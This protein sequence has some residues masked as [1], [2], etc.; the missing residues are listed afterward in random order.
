MTTARQALTTA[1]TD[2]RAT[3]TSLD[4]AF[5]AGAAAVV[6]ALCAS[7]IPALVDDS[8]IYLRIAANIGTGQGWLYNLTEVSNA[9][10]STSYTL[11]VAAIGLVLG[12]SEATL[13]TAYGLTLY[14]LWALQ[15]A[16]WHGEGRGRAIAIA[17]GTALG[18]VLLRSFGMESPLMLACVSA[19]ALSYRAQGDSWRT[20]A[21]AGLTALTRPEGIALLGLI[22]LVE[23]VRGRR[24]AWRSVLAAGLVILPWVA[25]ATWY[26]GT[27]RSQTGEIKALQ[28]HMGWWATQPGFLFSFLGQPRWLPATLA[29]A[30]GGAWLAVRRWLRGDAFALLCIGFGVIQVLGYQLM[31]APSGYVWY[32]IPGNFAVDLGV[33]LFGTWGIGVLARR[34]SW[35]PALAVAVTLVAL[36]VLMR[37]GMSPQVR[38][39][40][41]YRLAAEYRA[42]GH[43]LDAH[44]APGDVVAAT[45]IG[46]LGWYSGLGVL[47][48]HGLAHPRA[49]PWLRQHNL[50]WWWDTGER[51]RYV[52]I[53]DKPWFGEPGSEETWPPALNAEFFR[54]YRPAFQYE[55]LRVFER[56]G[57]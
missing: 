35:R 9:A 16:A 14:A 20:G 4:A 44:G 2:E 49:V 23:L 41:E 52:V 56:N 17:T 26:F 57:S 22:G 27:A 50:H 15:Y 6:T 24:I 10:T 47:D 46:Y 8:F 55:T 32:F 19:T 37:L 33:M 11:L 25:F 36:P 45:E 12:Y 1:A 39:P 38:L 28:R 48:I 31:D 7:L 30:T 42:V 53:H 29:L 13:A 3:W 40:G 51:P 5:L 34:F 43:W 18:G 21:L 54:Q